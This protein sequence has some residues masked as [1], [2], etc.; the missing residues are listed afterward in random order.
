MNSDADIVRRIIETRNAEVAR[1]YAQGEIDSV[2]AVF[3]ADAWQMPPNA[4]ALI[5]RD[6]IRAYWS[7]TVQWGKWEF[8]LDAQQVDVSGS[9][10]IE[11]GKYR[12]NFIAG[13][14]APPGMSSF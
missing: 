8:L 1:W 7:Q 12:L 5:G 6:A 2:A 10:A 14:A 3:S 9:M 11:R 13:P 4:P